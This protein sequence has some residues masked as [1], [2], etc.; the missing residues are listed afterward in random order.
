MGAT[1]GIIKADTSSLDD[2]SCSVVPP[3]TLSEL[4]RSSLAGRHPRIVATIDNDC[5]VVR[6]VYI[7]SCSTTSSE[8]GA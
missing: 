5:I 4:D 2:G 3:P 8:V 6:S 1:I 7:P